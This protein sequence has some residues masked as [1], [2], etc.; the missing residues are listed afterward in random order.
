MNSRRPSQNQPRPRALLHP[1][2]TAWCS[3]PK[4]SLYLGEHR[5]TR[6]GASAYGKN[7]ERL[8][9]AG[10]RNS[11]SEEQIPS[12][13]CKLTNHLLQHRL[14]RFMLE[15]RK[16]EEYPPDTLCLFKGRLYADFWS[17]LDTETTRRLYWSGVDEQLIME[18]MGHRSLDGVCS[19]ERTSKEQLEV[20][21]DIAHLSAPEPK[22]Q[23]T[24]IPHTIEWYHTVRV[25]SRWLLTLQSGTVRSRY[26]ADGL[27]LAQISLQ[28]CCNITFNVT[29]GRVWTVVIILT[30]CIHALLYD[31][32][33]L[34]QSGDYRCNIWD[35]RVI[36]EN[37]RDL[38]PFEASYNFYIQSG[39]IT[40]VICEI[41]RVI[42][43]AISDL[44]PFQWPIRL[45]CF[46]EV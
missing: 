3:K 19:Y 2:Q 44:N 43:G 42:S 24:L 36:S 22:K 18:H 35:C 13:I 33:Q 21:P 10:Q 11:R 25:H 1:C 39:E 17:T 45:Q 37:Y 41:C 14:S 38:N 9:T 7:G 16:K 30:R 31:T 6:F 28:S 26:T 27:A 23:K 34:L 5:R 12:D 20:V 4:G 40:G 29:C 15:V 8:E 46:I 32:V